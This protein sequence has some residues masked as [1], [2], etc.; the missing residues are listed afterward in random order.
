MR[1]E[2]NPEI[3]QHV[4]ASRELPLFDESGHGAC[5][6]PSAEGE[7][8]AGTTNAVT[9]AAAPAPE[10]AHA[11]RS[12]PQQSHAAARSVVNL[13]RTRDEIIRILLNCGPQ[14]DE[15]IWREYVYRSTRKYSTMPKVSPSGLRSRRAEL[16]KMGLVEQ[17]GEGVTQAGRTCAKWRV[18]R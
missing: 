7:T 5:V 9:M 18:R 1:G 4:A 2:N 17:C 14:T 3:R 15:Q 8:G 11:R 6:L 12:D 13:G 10:Q 16:V